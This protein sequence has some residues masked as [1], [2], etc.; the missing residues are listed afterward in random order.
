M[1]GDNEN[2][3][4]QNQHGAFTLD[5]VKI[6][7]NR[8]GKRI[9]RQHDK[10]LMDSLD[11]MQEAAM[12]AIESGH[13]ILTKGMGI[14]SAS[15]AKQDQARQNQNEVQMFLVRLYNDW[16]GECKKKHYSPIMAKSV[17]CEGETL[18]ATDEAHRMRKG[19]A[20]VNLRNCL[21]VYCVLR[22]WK[23]NA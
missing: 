12:Y 15:Y 6:T 7:H 9:R 17:I 20:K 21:D 13:R 3:D 18:S 11:T 8:S 19:T 5:N 10:R 22:G 23:N 14:K 16:V 4:I 1:Y 2:L